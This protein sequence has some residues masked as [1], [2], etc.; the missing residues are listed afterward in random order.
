[1]KKL[2]LIL[3]IILTGT[4]AIHAQ[5]YLTKNGKIS[6]FSKTD[7][8]NIDAVNNQVVSVITPSTGSMAFSVLITGFLFKKALMQE[9]FNENYME[10]AKYPKA[11]F[12][13]TIADISKVDFKKD[14]SYNVSVTGDLNIHNVTNKVTVPGVIVVKGG[15]VSAST[16]FKVKLADYKISVPKLVEGNI[17]KTIEIKVDCNY[18]PR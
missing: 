15:K 18:D 2:I 9:H 17:S 6:F 12:K 11:T 5:S 10:S 3:I 14:G 13:G 7:I 16:T 1:M 8:E 4:Q